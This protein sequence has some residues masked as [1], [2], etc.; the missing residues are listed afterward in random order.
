MAVPIAVTGIGIVALGF[1]SVDI[2]TE[3]IKL[4]LPEVLLK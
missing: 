2:V 1:Y 4:G 3:I